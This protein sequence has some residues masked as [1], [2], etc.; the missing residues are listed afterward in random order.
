[1]YH[2]KLEDK[3]GLLNSYYVG[4]NRITILTCTVQNLKGGFSL[5]PHV[6]EKENEQQSPEITR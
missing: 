4:E 6:L 3:Q 2:E 1:M 5:N